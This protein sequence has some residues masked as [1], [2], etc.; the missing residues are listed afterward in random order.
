MVD[1]RRM[2]QD[3][4]LELDSVNLRQRLA[5]GALRASEL[6]AACL[7]RIAEREPQIGAWAWLDA[8][9]AR[10]E[11]E[12]RD[13]HRQCGRPTGP[14]HGLPVGVKDIVDTARIPTEN[15]T[16]I[17]AGRVP[18]EDAAIVERLKAAGA[19]VLGKTVTT[20]LAYLNPSRT[21]NPHDPD[22]TPGGSSSG[23]A[24]AVAAG[25]VP[26]A[27][28]T[29]TAGSVIR[30]AAF[31]GVVGF[32]PSFGA[33]ARRGILAQAPSLDTVGVFAADV[34]GAALIAEALFGHDPADP[35]TSPQ[36]TPRLLGTAMA[37]PPVR[38][39]FAFW[40]PP[41]WQSADEEMRAAVLEVVERLGENCFEIALPAAFAEADARRQTI[42]LAEMSKC[43]YGYER[44]AGERLS[45]FLIERLQEAKAIP[46]RDYLAALDWRA[47]LTAGLDEVFARCDALITPAALGPAPAGLETT[48][49]PVFNGIWTLA[50]T[51]AVTLP[52]FAASNGLPMGLQLVGRRG[53]DG[54]LLRTA[55]W[56]A[57]HLQAA[58]AGGGQT[59]EVES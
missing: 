39:T 57:A 16:P 51:P 21:R 19:I 28:G 44:R 36:P 35:A 52:L 18:R 14:L 32:K 1:R 59:E 9:H 54:R 20:E 17:D 22:H 50:G 43:F 3:A 49:D 55:H 25:M 38:P 12:A 2:K 31:C 7:A 24:A 15:G 46:A 42:Q 27:I 58:A 56:L 29:Q 13:R 34:A 8:D 10:A 37:E 5:S 41:A 48:G 6:M 33:I 23:S 4:L 47:L 53:D 11:A 26:L 45:P 40:R 30:P